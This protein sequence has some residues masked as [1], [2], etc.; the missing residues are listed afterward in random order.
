MNKVLDGK[1]VSEK[2]K[3]D[4]KDKIR[5]ISQKITLAVIQ[6]GDNPA[7]NIY[8]NQ[9]K[10]VAEELG[11]D[12]LHIKYSDNIDQQ[13]LLNKIEDLN[14]N[15]DVYGIFIQ[16]PIS[17]HLDSY[18]LINKIDPKKDVDGLTTINMGL[19]L[20]DKHLIIPCTP[21]GIIRLLKSYNISIA[22]KNVVIVGK[23]NLVGKP[24]IY[25][26]LK[27]KATVTICH[28]ATE[29]LSKHTQSADILVVACG[30]KH[31]INSKMIKEKSIIIDVGINKEND[32]I[33]GDVDYNDVY[34]KVSYITPVPGGVGPM[35]VIMLMENVIESY[36]N[37]NNV[38]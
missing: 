10:K 34:D 27:E 12:F 33:Y 24:L 17:D 16:L 36:F 8:I 25:L 4:L 23:S 22:K 1:Y 35:T 6:V 11:L 31:L 9:K 2:I 28:S 3:N 15:N 18:E 7:S 20:N 37:I 30:C 19:L 26:F 14:K 21:K 38:K 32:K 13:S 5:N 29:Q